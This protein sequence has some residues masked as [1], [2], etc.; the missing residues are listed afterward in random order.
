DTVATM[1]L[2]TVLSD[3]Q[4]IIEELTSR[5]RTI[6]EGG[7][8]GEG[9]G[10]R[11]VT[12]QIKEAVVSSSSLWET[13]QR[14]FRA[15]RAREARLAELDQETMIREREAEDQKAAEMLEIATRAEI[16]RR[17]AEAEARAF[18][19]Q[20]AEAVRRAKV[21]AESLA[22]SIEFEKLKSSRR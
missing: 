11:I 15:E 1:S 8:E 18:D 21:E 16:A 20:Q 14:P 6:M 10:L 12:V 4:P 9:L 2:D 19:D 7:A 3:R 5:L 13:L 22:E 17:R